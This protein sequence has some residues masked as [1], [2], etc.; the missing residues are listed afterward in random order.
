NIQLTH[1][2]AQ[3]LAQLV[4]RLG[5]SDCR[6]LATSDIEAYL[7]MDGINQIMKALAEEGYAPR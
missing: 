7:M 5:F 3:A 4:K 2:E 1:R 6:G